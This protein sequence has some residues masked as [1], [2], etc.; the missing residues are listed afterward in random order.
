M[1]IGTYVG[2]A[3]VGIF[4]YW[5]L[6]YNWA[7]DNHTLIKYSELSHWGQCQHWEQFSVNNYGQFGMLEEKPC[8]YFTHGKE[9]ASTLSLTV[10]VI[11]EMFN[12]MNAL[13]EDSSIITVGIF[14]NL[15]LIAAISLS[16]LLH[17]LILYI[18]FLAKVFG[19]VPLSLN[20]WL[21]VL[22]FSFPVVIIDEILKIISRRRNKRLRMTQDIHV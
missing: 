5:Y 18:P 11:I 6:F 3:T 9:T 2:L 13:S 15:W 16:V 8:Q 22:I 20:D 19:T 10:L 7:G 14:S 17:C 4:I 12:A 21:L 1:V